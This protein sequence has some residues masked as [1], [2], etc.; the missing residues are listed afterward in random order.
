M[1][2]VLS[3]T[4]VLLVCGH[5]ETTRAQ[6]AAIISNTV[7]MV[8]EVRVAILPPL[9]PKAVLPATTD[10]QSQLSS[11]V[12]SVDLGI[13]ASSIVRQEI[14][15]LN[16]G[17]VADYGLQKVFFPAEITEAPITIITPD[18]RKLACR[19]TFLALHD[20]VSGQSLLLGEVR[21][22]IGELI[23]NNT[24]VY[25]KAFDTIRADIRYRYNKYFLEQDIIL[26]EAIKLPKEFQAENVQLEVW[27]EWIDSTPD[28]KESQTIDL[29]PLAATGEQ[30][31]VT[32][33]D[34]HL[35]FGAM[36]IGDGYAFALQN[37][38]EKIPVAKTFGRIE[39]RDWLIE[40]V[41]YTAL[42]PR[43]ER[44]PKSHA[45][46]SPDRIE[47]DRSK[48]IR[49]M[50]ARTNQKFSGNPMLIGK[51]NP[52]ETDS[53]V[54]DFIISSSVPVPTGL[55]A[56]WTGGGTNLDCV[57]VAHATMLN[58]AG[59][60]AG[61]VGQAFNLDGSNDRINASNSAAL[62]FGSGADFSIEAW[63]KP[64]TNNTTYGVTTIVDKRN[65][66][67]VSQGIGYEMS[68]VN[69][70]LACRLSDSIANI[71]T[72]YG[73]A[74]P[75]L[76]IDGNFHH[77]AMTVNR[78]STTG[79]K[80]YVDGSVV[81]TFDPT[82][83][84]GDL[85]NDE[86]VRIGNHATASLNCYFRG[87]IDEPSI[88]NRALAAAEIQ[89]IYG[90]G[91]AGKAN[92]NCMTAPTNIVA[93]WPGDANVYDL[94][95]TNSATLLNGATYVSAVVGQGF[96]FDGV[97]DGVTVPNDEALNIAANEN[98]TIE[99]WINAISNNTTYGVTTIVDK[100]DAPNISQC[101]GYV[102]CLVNGSVHLR[103]SDSIS[104]IGA[105]FGGGP[106]LRDGGYHHVAVTVDRGATNGGHLYVDGS[107]V[108][109]FNPT[110]VSGSLSN[111]ESVRIGVHAQSG[112]NGYHKGII[113]EV[114]FYRRALTNTEITAL[115]SAGSAGKCKVD[116]DG[117]GLTD[118]QEAFLGT[119]PNRP[120]SD[121]DGL[122][123]GDEVF[124]Y[125]TKPN[126]PDTDGDGISDGIEVIQG[127]NPTAG[128]V[129][130]SSNQ[131]K[132]TVF[133]PLN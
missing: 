45:S 49:S 33:T 132:L 61:K 118:L 89:A 35:K 37:E 5:A 110:V 27:S 98:F 23:G 1:K 72:G 62:N 34:E 68:L 55:L 115:Y 108:L 60:G 73:P 103:I 82:V 20:D 42:K 126:N 10:T 129:P 50:H 19:A 80:L 28:T 39:G 13:G 107:S 16:D 114:T 21:E 38:G 131:T 32:A 86:P 90:A 47:S 123:D 133:T 9:A 25:P 116:T 7:P 101:L 22:S 113:D 6:D 76:R 88:Y 3:I 112:F 94:A 70:K 52:T 93:W 130:D 117:D 53:L 105:A 81:L 58:G 29:R 109:E 30:A 128:A 120:D 121:G 40:H 43:L 36:R 122:T 54:L 65:A 95:R 46:L 11:N 99:A 97:D 78:D 69:G 57:G 26:H 106:D 24:V 71:G 48:L 18:G 119:N 66:P 63:I 127:R 59:Y 17:A 75:D 83:E 85:S 64:L 77:V 104:G 41:D 84:P 15:L 124:V 79:G 96:Y 2:S 44:L 31:A 67:N 74:G 87:T 14:R 12:V 51:A 102:F 91:A 8:E 56:W 111:A 4:T 100:R 92:P 125:R